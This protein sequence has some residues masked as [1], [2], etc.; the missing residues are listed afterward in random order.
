[1]FTL[2]LHAFVPVICWASATEML[3]N[4]P[5]GYT[6]YAVRGEE[7]RLIEESAHADLKPLPP[8]EDGFTY[9]IRTKPQPPVRP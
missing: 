1:M 5:D 6:L 8:L 2:I 7:E 9:V 4:S 3:C